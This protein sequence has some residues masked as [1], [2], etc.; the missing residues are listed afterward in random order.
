LFAVGGID[1]KNIDPML[2][3]LGQD[4]FVL[5]SRPD[6][7]NDF[8]SGF[9]EGVSGHTSVGSCGERSCGWKDVILAF[10]A[11]LCHARLSI[12]SLAS[13]FDY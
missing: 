10:R 5:A 11:E 6:G 9:P 13:A 2:D 7:C 4:L 1:P 8:G 12:D 3:Q